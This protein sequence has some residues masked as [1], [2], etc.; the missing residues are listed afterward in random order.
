MD[1]YWEMFSSHVAKADNEA[2]ARKVIQELV[3]KK[4]DCVKTYIN[5]PSQA[6]KA[7]IDEAHRN[8][9][10][11]T[12]HLGHVDARQ[13]VLFGIDG[14]EHASGIAEASLTEDAEERAAAIQDK[15]HSP[16]GE[17]WPV[18]PWEFVSPERLRSLIQLLVDRNVTIDPTLGVYD[19]I[20]HFNDQ[21]RKEN[22]NLKYIHFSEE[23]RHLWIAEN[24][25]EIF[26]TKPWGPKEFNRALEQQDARMEFVRAFA[27][28]GG[29]VVA[30]S[31]TPNPF[32]VPG[33]S[34]HRELE[35]LV[36]AGLTPLE[37]LQT[38]TL[39][40]AKT[41]RKETS[42]GTISA[43]RIADLV[44]LNGDPLTDIEQ[45]KNLHQVVKNGIVYDP[46]TLLAEGN[47][48]DQRLQ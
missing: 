18:Q 41:L 2:Q 1:A 24:Y 14:I 30:G 42:L 37:A 16:T 26:G 36:E 15:H 23:L 20:A 22:P 10:P 13:A 19:N 34:L 48:S 40:A 32:V 35:L 33:F 4:V 3:K 47:S 29:V 21:K 5:L 27:K 12:G 31:D 9:L 8:N 45:T 39:N 17:N 43:G 38:A 44:I 11:V 6:L 28:A 46:V 25:F 7:A